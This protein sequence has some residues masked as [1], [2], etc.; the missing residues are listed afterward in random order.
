[1]P[2]RFRAR[3]TGYTLIELLVVI[4]ILGVLVGLLMPAVQKVREA[5]N[6]VRC[7]N[8]LRQLTLAS[9]NCHDQL[10]SLPPG[11]GWFPSQQ[12]PGAYG[13]IFFHLLPYVEQDNLYRNSFFAGNYF[14]GNNEVH[15]HPVPLFLCPS[16]PSVNPP[17]VVLD[18]IGIAWGASSYACNAQAVCSVRD[19][20]ELVSPETY[21]RIPASFPDG[22]SNTLLFAEKYAYCNNSNYPEG[23]NL[24]AYWLTGANLR[25]YHPGFAVSWTAYSIGPGSK[26][27]IQPLPYNG[28]CDPTL[29]STPHG[30][31]I[32]VGMGDGSVRFLSAGISPFTWWYL[33]TPSGGE[34]I[35]TDAF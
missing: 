8:N 16:D 4:A 23:G 26:F 27:L 19:N 17:G 25:P 15:A 31:G 30:S 10:G 11:L 24:W 29:A 28:N 18:H 1:M 22:T 7:S 2:K 33:C 20:G 32:H 3:R 34:V 6:Y 35:P 12:P 14:A 21:A 13:T 5:A 9:H